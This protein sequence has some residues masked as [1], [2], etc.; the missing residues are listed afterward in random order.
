MKYMGVAQPGFKRLRSVACDRLALKISA[1]SVYGFTGKVQRRSV[2]SPCLRGFPQWSKVPMGGR[3][4]VSF[5]V[6]HLASST[7]RS[8][9]CFKDRPA[10]H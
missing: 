2:S 5:E 3:G 10:G 6:Q 1:N 9:S 4:H 7:W 8:A